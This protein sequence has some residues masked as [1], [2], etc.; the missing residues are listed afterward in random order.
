MKKTICCNPRP[1]SKSVLRH[2]GLYF[3][4][5]IIAFA[6]SGIHHRAKGQDPQFSQFY[7]NPLY[8]NPALAGTSLQSRLV[9][10]YRNQWPKSGNTYVTYNLTYD[11]FVKSIN[12]GVGIN[13]YYDRELNGVVNSINS[14]FFYSYHVKAN[15]RLFFTGALQ[16]GFIYKEFNTSGLIFPGMI[17]P[18]NGNITG[19]YPLP[20]ED[21]QKIFP[22]VSFGLAGQQD[23]I[24]FGFALHHLTEPNQSIIEGDQ[25]GKLPMKM[26]VHVGAKSRE[27]H[28]KLYSKAFTLSPNLIYQQQG[29]YKQINAGLYYNQDWL[30]IGAWYRN[31]LSVRPDALI[32]M[33]GFSTS[34]FQLGYSFDYSLSDISAY[35]YGSHEVSLIFFFGENNHRGLYNST[36]RIPVM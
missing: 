2:F 32:G 23:N 3:S 20:A 35:S 34:A 17:D 25:V 15:D 10:N 6:W 29:S 5:L 21:G 36:M 7:S 26:T 14:S 24:Y 1:L 13:L 11:K 18:E 4:L 16:L 33:V 27:Y 8:L 22:D 19:I 31:N 12:G 30:T 28:R 9:S